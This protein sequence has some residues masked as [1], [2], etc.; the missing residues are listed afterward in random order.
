MIRR[1][2]SIAVTILWL[3]LRGNLA[4]G[5]E[6]PPTTLTIDVEN[7]VEYQ[8]DISDP[9]KFGTS[10]GITPSNGISAFAVVVAIGDIVSVNGQPAKGVY[11][12]R[13]LDIALSTA[14]RPR[15]SIADISHASLRSHTFEILKPDGTPI[16]TIMSFG[17]DGGTPPPGAP[18]Y[19]FATRGNYTIYGGTGAYLGA[20]GELVQRQQA[21][22]KVP[23]RAASMAEDPANRRINGGGT[24]LFVLHVLPR[25]TPQITA[26]T[27]SSDFTLVTAA[28]P[29]AP[30]EFLSL[31][32]YWLGP[33]APSV[34]PGQ[35][36]PASPPAA[37]NSPVE[38]LVNGKSA[39]VVGAVGL[40]AAVDGYQ[41]NFRLPP[42]TGKGPATIQVNSAWIASA[43]FTIT[44]Q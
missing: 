8:G 44:V 23:P 25:R 37:V 21:L 2:E 7:V 17:L 40:P 36:F 22:E 18:S 14:P 31:F 29:A 6:P 38:V 3:G 16:G 10:A 43:L 30:G 11:V 15:Q 5:Q 13:P 4:F 24:I 20:R 35:P 26:V 9:T 28:K 39:E 32:A 19:S 41:V 42:D 1:F 12:G 27:H 34:D 33:T